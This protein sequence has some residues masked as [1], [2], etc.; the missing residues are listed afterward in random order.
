M[1]Q[2]LFQTNTLLRKLEQQIQKLA[3][4]SRLFRAPVPHT[5]CRWANAHLPNDYT[6]VGRAIQVTDPYGHVDVLALPKEFVVPPL[7]GIEAFRAAI[8]SEH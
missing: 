5:L 7:D 6:V 3:E 8:N 2:V 4:P 1:N